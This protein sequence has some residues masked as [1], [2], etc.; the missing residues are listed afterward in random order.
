MAWWKYGSQPNQPIRDVNPTANSG[1]LFRNKPDPVPVYIPATIPIPISISQPVR[2]W[3]QLARTA[4]PEPTSVPVTPLPTF[5]ITTEQF[6]ATPQRTY[7]PDSIPTF[8]PDPTTVPKTPLPTFSNSRTVTSYMTNNN[9]D[10]TNNPTDNPTTVPKTSLPTVSKPRTV[11]PYMT[12]D[13]PDPTNSPTD[14]PTTVPITPLPT[15]TESR[16]E[17]TRRSTRRPV[18]TSSV[19]TTTTRRKELKRVYISTPLQSE[20]KCNFWRTKCDYTKPYVKLFPQK[21]GQAKDFEYFQIDAS[22]FDVDAH[23]EFGTDREK[24]KWVIIFAGWGSTK[25]RIAE[26]EKTKDGWDDYKKVYAAHSKDQWFSVRLV[27]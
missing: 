18:T 14:N 4:R 5:T 26:R 20:K 10:P 27:I 1:G 24:E 8:Q 23:I 21:G 7:S 22:D 11:T 6:T 25:T 12:N 15:F 13:Y 2:K 19:R 16:P 17:S 9:P 3:S